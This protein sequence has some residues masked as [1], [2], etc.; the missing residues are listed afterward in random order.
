MSEY[1]LVNWDESRA[2]QDNQWALHISAT[3]EEIDAWSDE[4]STRQIVEAKFDQRL[5][6]NSNLPDRAAVKSAIGEAFDNSNWR[7]QIES[8]NDS[9]NW[10]PW[11]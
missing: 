2:S 6:G 3:G 7:R 8:H 10:L 1:T 4:P 11:E 9:S 5:P